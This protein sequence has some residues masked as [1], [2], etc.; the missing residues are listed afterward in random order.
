MFTLDQVTAAQKNNVESLIGL[1]AQVFS[2][3][4]KLVELNIATAK[5]AFNDAAK[6]AEAAL[7]VKDA[8]EFI[9]LQSAQIQPLAEKVSAYGRKAYEIAATSTAEIRSTVEGKLKEAQ[10][11][12]QSVVATATSAATPS[13]KR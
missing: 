1:S 6:Q 9:A 3:V 12:A 13:K 4:E 10:A 2:G 5:A 8:Q 11:A 7:N